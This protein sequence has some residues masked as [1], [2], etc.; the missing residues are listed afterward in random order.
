MG[1]IG[2]SRDKATHEEAS[3]LYGIS[4]GQDLPQKL[5]PFSRNQFD[6]LQRAI[7]LMLVSTSL[8]DWER[9]F[10]RD[11]QAKLNR[12][13]PRT[14]FSAKQYR[15]LMKLTRKH[16]APKQTDGHRSNSQ[17]S[18]TGSQSRRQRYR[19]RPSLG[20]ALAAVALGF[21]LVYK[22]AERFPEYFGPIVAISS[23]QEIVGPVT[24]VR[25]GDTIEVSG[26]PI[27]FGSLDCAEAGTSDGNRAT[28]RMR[29][30]IRGQT[31][32]CYLN[33]RTSYDRQIGSC[34]LQ[35]GRDL[36]GIMISEG[37]C[38]RFW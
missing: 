36:G 30:L 28:E 11:M 24:H 21:V 17:F 37:Y 26:T 13:G 8:N 19:W 27:R 14:S 3:S 12:Y 18:R 20:L 32:T 6:D 23:S 22:G 1:L 4:S 7:R 35:D 29:A 9:N 31:L 25:D 15:L 5:M 34:R 2:R 10:L 33:G 38:Q 16:A